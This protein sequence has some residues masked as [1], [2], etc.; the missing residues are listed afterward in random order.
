MTSRGHL[1]TCLPR[2]D[3]LP[4]VVPLLAGREAR[5]R[6]KTWRKITA[7][8]LWANPLRLSAGRRLHLTNFRSDQVM[9]L[10]T[11]QR[12]AY[13]VRHPAIGTFFSDRM[14]VFTKNIKNRC[15]RTAASAR[16]LSDCRRT[17]TF[18][19]D[20]KFSIRYFIRTLVGKKIGPNDF[21][22]INIGKPRYITFF[23]LLK[24][25]LS[26]PPGALASL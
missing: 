24:K 23:F 6:R 12:N 15:I 16:C 21:M 2:P 8:S 18:D 17:Q 10:D 26:N 20:D 25:F 11:L 19:M 4:L 7:R 14:S 5:E 22:P 9:L 3:S 1:D 13:K